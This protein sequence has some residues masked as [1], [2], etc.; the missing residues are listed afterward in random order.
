MFDFFTARVR[1]PVNPTLD[2]VAK[3]FESGEITTMTILAS[4]VF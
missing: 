1:L 3:Q 2:Q 4:D